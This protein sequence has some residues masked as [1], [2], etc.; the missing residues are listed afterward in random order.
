MKIPPPI[1]NILISRTD[2]I[3]DVM[4]T[5]PLCGFIKQHF[6]AVKI[7]FIGRTY[8]VPI[9]KACQ[10]ID[11][12]V[13]FDELSW[14]P[15]EKQLYEF[16]QFGADVIVH[17]FPNRN[18]AQLALK[19]NIKYRVGTSHRWFHW[20]TCNKLVNLGRKNSELHESQ[21]NIQLLKVLMELETPNLESLAQLTGFNQIEKPDAKIEAYLSKTKFN[22]ILHPKSKGSAREW[23]TDNFKQLISLLPT[24][25]FHI[26]ITGT[27]AE[28]KLMNDLFNAVPNLTN[29]CGLLDLE[30][31]IILIAN[32]DGLVAASTGPLHIAA[33]S[34]I[35]A[36]GIF[37]PI[38]P[39]HPGRWQ[40]IGKK[41]KVFVNDQSCQACKKT[42]IC[43]CILKISPHQIAQYITEQS[44]KN[45]RNI[46]S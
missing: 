27:Q 7:G 4:L 12:I 18:I 16:N 28:G 22:L 5:L 9:L 34:G 13:N 17:V 11:Y 31:L 30:E 38:K 37:P 6:P 26:I 41:V 44:L 20:F 2:S 46:T 35:H 25:K 33:A 39:M 1:Q 45:E 21:L 3:G 42:N 32:A 29:L 8:T 43:T 36:I 15:K 23:G 40:P 19:A 10:H 24:E 14:F